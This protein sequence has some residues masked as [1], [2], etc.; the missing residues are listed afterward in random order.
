MRNLGGSFGIAA[1]TALQSRYQQQYVNVLGSHVT[2]YD[3]AASHLLDQL[4]G[5]F[6]A[7]GSGPVTAQ[8]QALMALFGII[9]QQAAMLSFVDVFRLMAIV[10]LL[11]LPLIFLMKKPPKGAAAGMAH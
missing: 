9:Q 4:R 2:P 6:S 8:S 7:G 11:M 1:V 3:P 5:A 10:F